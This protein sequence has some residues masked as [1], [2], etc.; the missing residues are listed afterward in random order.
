M[1]KQKRSPNT[2]QKIDTIFKRDINNI[3]MPFDGLVSPE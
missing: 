3:I 1:G 2:Y